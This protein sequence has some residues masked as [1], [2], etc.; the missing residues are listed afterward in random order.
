MSLAK[1]VF[2]LGVDH[3]VAAVFDDERA[4]VEA[5]DVGKRLVQNGRFLDEVLHVWPL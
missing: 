2:E 5:A 3:G 1:L 4:P